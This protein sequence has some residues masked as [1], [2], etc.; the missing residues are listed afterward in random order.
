LTTPLSLP[1]AQ[2][3]NFGA[4]AIQA[5][6]AGLKP[7]SAMESAE[8]KNLTEAMSAA[9][10]AGSHDLA[11]KLQD[12]I[13]KLLDSGPDPVAKLEEMQQ[14][15]ETEEILNAAVAGGDS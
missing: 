3:E 9:R 10:K 7:K 6:I 2:N 4:Q 15:K 14:Q 8:I 1:G 13:D 11:K 12:K 5:L